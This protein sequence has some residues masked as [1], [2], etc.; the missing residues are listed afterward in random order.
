[1]RAIVLN[2]L[3]FASTLAS[4]QRYTSNVEHFGVEH[5]LSHHDARNVVVDG[6]GLVW[7]GTRNG[8]NR[9][10][11]KRFKSFYTQQG[12]AD[13]NI[14]LLFA[15]G[16]VLWCVHKSRTTEV[17]NDI[18]FFHAVEENIVDFSEYSGLADLEK[19]DINAVFG[20]ENEIVFRADKNGETLWFLK[21]QGETAIKLNYGIPVEFIAS[22][23]D[24]TFW[25]QE[26]QSNK[27]TKRNVKGELLQAVSTKHLKTWRG[28]FYVD[29]RFAEHGKWLY[30][31]DSLYR[32]DGNK[33]KWVGGEW[34]YNQMENSMVQLPSEY[35]RWHQYSGRLWFSV[36]SSSYLLDS[37]GKTY[38]AYTNEQEYVNNTDLFIEHIILQPTSSGLNIFSLHPSKFNSF[39]NG[40]LGGYRSIVKV[41][42][43]Y[44][45]CNFEGLK[46]WNKKSNT[47]TNHLSDVGFCAITH[48]GKGYSAGRAVLHEIDTNHSVKSYP[49]PMAHEVWS[50][51]IVGNSLFYSTF[52]LHEYNLSTREDHFIS[53]TQYPE[54]NQATIYAIQPKTENDFWLCSTAGLFTWNQK[55]GEFL[56]VLDEVNGVSEFQHL[57]V[58][59][60]V[61]WLASGGKG[62][63]KYDLTSKSTQYFDFGHNGTNIVHSVYADNNGQLWLSTDYGIVRFNK[64]THQARVFLESDG[65]LSNEFNRISHLQEADGSLIF[66][67]VKGLVHFHPDSISDNLSH[68]PS[69][70]P[71]VADVW[72]YQK[73]G[74]EISQVTNQFNKDGTITIE[75]QDRFLSFD[76]ATNSIEYYDQVEFSYKFKSD[77]NWKKLP[78]N[79]LAFN[80]LP[81]GK[82][83]ITVRAR[84]PNGFISDKELKFQIQ[85]LKPI[86]LRTWFIVLVVLILLAVSILF[87]HLRTR[88]L[89]KQKQTLESEV[90]KRTKKIREDKKIIEHQAEELKSLD[91]MKNHFFAN[92]SHELRNPL[93]LIVGPVENLLSQKDIKVPEVVKAQMNLTLK[94]AKSLQKRV[95]EILA[96]SK[97]DSG[98][99]NLRLSSINVSSFVKR[100]VLSFESLALLKGAK[101]V[102]INDIDSELVAEVDV[103][104]TEKIINN[105]LTNAIKHAPANTK[106]E[107]Q[108]ENLEHTVYC[109]TV[110]DQGKGVDRVEQDKIFDR[111][112]QS[113]EGEKA[114]G[115]GLGLA[116]SSELAHLMGGKI[117]LDKTY[118]EG[119]RFKFI[120]KANTSKQGAK[121]E[122]FIVDD[123]ALNFETTPNIDL[124]S[125][126]YNANILVVDDNEEMRFY[127]KSILGANARIYEAENGREALNVL[128]KRKIDLITSDLMMPEMDGMELLEA[129]KANEETKNIPVIMV[130]AR[131]D[132][133]DK[134]TALEIGVNDYIT[135]PFYAREL[136]ARVNN[137]LSK[138]ANRIEANNEQEPISTDDDLQIDKILEAIKANISNNEFNVVD[139]AEQVGYSERQLRRNIKRL[140]GVTPNTLIKELKLTQARTFLEQQ[141]YATVA[142]VMYA[143]GFKS[144]GHFTKDYFNRFGKKPSEYFE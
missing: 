135:K 98:K 44:L 88:T 54:L 29:M 141:Q 81:F 34:G 37:L 124:K 106:I 87:I 52:G 137:L 138:A 75:P 27:I 46:T 83:Q 67:G 2:F 82:H 119:A 40:A 60:S 23:Q 105:L 140:K 61:L 97:I 30:A 134:L 6:R 114:G 113:K 31:Y 12:L 100:V 96:L 115:T 77:E 1:M 42:S 116:L 43:N 55:T 103:D 78:S 90:E 70:I 125:T 4:A 129:L 10:D 73:G 118:N 93:T 128:S 22:N 9:F 56:K 58:D 108:L 126:H 66:G 69:L 11:G 14:E 28:E 122:D 110:T 111:Y 102:F 50:M 85:A 13:N 144:A 104:N 86:Y 133:A 15:D 95:S 16:N 72:L 7:V 59:D 53:S 65:L 84:L 47:L 131:A 74:N 123:K 79:R 94:N 35:A 132:D 120:F 101:L 8:L 57:Y 143:C 19:T 92:I 127:I 5:G 109:L 17:I 21:K 139:L 36:R 39:S 68:K 136:L 64:T 117:E 41:G 32:I 99:M 18:T 45:V 51:H 112:Y 38:Y 107:V 62:L 89:Q 121:T 91:K 20:N 26:W 49:L 33:L 76:L 142:E 48:N 3:L 25:F 130:T 63:V 24:G 71:F 80:V